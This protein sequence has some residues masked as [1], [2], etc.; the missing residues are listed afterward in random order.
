[1][2]VPVAVSGQQ[3]QGSIQMV[4]AHTPIARIRPGRPGTPGLDLRTGPLPVRPPRRTRLPQ[5]ENTYPNGDSTHLLAAC[6]G[7]VMLRQMALVVVPSHVHDGDLLAA[8]G[9]FSV[10]YALTVR[11][12]VC[13][14]AV[15]S[16]GGDIHIS[17][18]VDGAR[19][20]SARGSI[21]VAG[22]ISGT[23]AQR[24]RL[25]AH[26]DIHCKA[27]VHADVA[28]GRDIHLAT[29]AHRC[30]LRAGA[31][32]YLRQSLE[33]GLREV[34]L[35][36]GGGVLPRLD[37]PQLVAMAPT[38]ERQY[39]RVS[40]WLP[41]TLALHGMPPL[42]FHPA[43]VEDLSAGGARCRLTPELIPDEGAIIQLKF[44]LPEGAEQVLAIARVVRRAGR[45]TIGV[46]FLQMRERDQAQLREVCMRMS[47][48]A[49]E[50]RGTRADRRGAAR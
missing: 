46:A 9:P 34:S 36:V 24:S 15:V 1:L 27:A 12:S 4:R 6:D 7:V 43:T 30:A 10:P 32:I 23:P 38:M 29:T 2:L 18:D 22:S 21:T 40:T 8:H 44:A 45:E 50:R 35:S 48:L 39:V 11:G 13:E 37:P 31:N 41:A 49:S 19:V 42:T 17:G 33:E 20:T 47:R 28:A 3:A 5:G 14:G 26:A 25:E 16:A